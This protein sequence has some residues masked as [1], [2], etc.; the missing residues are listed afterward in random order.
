MNKRLTSILFI[1]V[2]LGATIGL[3]S[4]TKKEDNGGG[5]PAVTPNSMEATV[6][7]RKFEPTGPPIVTYNSTTG[8]IDVTMNDKDQV[9]AVAIYFSTNDG[10]TQTFGTGN[11][12]GNAQ[13]S[14]QNDG[15][16]TATNGTLT[17][18]TNDKAGRI[19]AGTFSFNAVN[20]NSQTT[21]VSGGKFY[22][23]Y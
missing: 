15:L 18:T 7:G 17:L 8:N 2:L 19:A 11:C 13:T 9:S 23:K 14:S 21:S 6:G 5:K 12:F 20:V 1:I 22:V 4:C 16:Y 10:N 3:A